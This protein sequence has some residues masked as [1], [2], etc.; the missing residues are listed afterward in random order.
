[1]LDFREAQEIINHEISAIEI[2]REP[3][4]LYEPVKYILSTG[5]KRIRPA[6]V[7]MSCSL[8]SGQITHAVRPA[9]AIEFFHNF[10]LL[11][12]DIMDNSV[13]RRNKP[14]VHEKWNRN[15]AILSGDVMAILSYKFVADCPSGIL[16]AVLELFTETALQV[17]EGQQYDLDFEARTDI[18]VDDYLKMIELK[19]SAL[20]ASSLKLGAILGGASLADAV[21][22]YEFG[23]NFGIAFQLK[24]DILDVYGDT[25]MFG[26]KIGMDIIAN[27]KTYL[28]LKALEMAD[29]ETKNRLIKLISTHGLDPGEKIHAVKN[30]FTQL[31]IK[32]I[33]EEKSRDY[34]EY[35]L[36]MLGMVSVNDEN[37]IALKQ[38]TAQLIEREQ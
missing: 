21:T 35:A 8:F 14:T 24:D 13:L 15:V 33:T 2:S 6:L 32:K 9:L 27:K 1:M 12:D 34:Y 3:V 16:P 4:E 25:A 29:K 10:T 26:K 30:I 11:H 7:L 20:I 19:T 36:K 17:C 23:R 31:G 28:V 38:F 18:G 5:G 37:K 22:L